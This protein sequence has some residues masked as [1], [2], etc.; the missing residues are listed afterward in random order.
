MEFKPAYLADALRQ[1]TPID[2]WVKCHGVHWPA[3]DIQRELLRQRLGQDARL[4]RAEPEDD[5]SDPPFGS[6]GSNRPES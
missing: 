5:N 1:G 4:G 3:T 6:L 2:M